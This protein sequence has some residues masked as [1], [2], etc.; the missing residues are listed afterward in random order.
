MNSHIAPMH[1][2]MSLI[3]G[4]Q[5]HEASRQATKVA[6]IIFY[7]G[8]LSSAHLQSLVFVHSAPPR[9]RGHNSEVQKTFA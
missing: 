9:R 2:E 6:N 3:I 4:A 5:L 7:L 1:D 8:G